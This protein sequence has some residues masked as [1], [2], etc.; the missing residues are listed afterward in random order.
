MRKEIYRKKNTK[1]CGNWTELFLF[2][3][4]NSPS[5]RS[6]TLHCCSF[7]IPLYSLSLWRE[8]F[9]IHA[10]FNQYLRKNICHFRSSLAFLLVSFASVVGTVGVCV[11]VYLF[12]FNACDTFLFAICWYYLL[13]VRVYACHALPCATMKNAVLLHNAKKFTYSFLCVL[14]M[15]RDMAEGWAP[16]VWRQFKQPPTYI[17]NTNREKEKKKMRAHT[18]SQ[19]NGINRGK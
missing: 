11:C 3:L 16:V 19:Y 4:V 1:E 8:P 10:W 14:Y 7:F 6:T 18:T 9:T 17:H 12:S 2:L 13:C 15:A 5:Q